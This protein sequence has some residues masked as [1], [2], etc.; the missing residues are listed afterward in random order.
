M[1]HNCGGF[2]LT[3]DCEGLWGMADNR[4]VVRRGTINDS[5]LKLA[6]EYILRVLQEN[7]LKA[8]AAFVT[9]FA[10]Q[11]DLLRD[12]IPLIEQLAVF[13]PNWFNLILSALRCK[14]LDGWRG[15]GFYRAMSSAGF[16]MAWHGA[17]HL[18]L[19][20][21]T[22]ADAIALEIELASR[23]FQALGHTPRTV[24]FPRNEVGHLRELRGHGFDT[25]RI[26]LPS[27]IVNRLLRM[28]NEWN[29]WDSGSIHKPAMRGDW[30]ISPAG[31]VLNWPS[32]ARGAVPVGTTINRWK[33]ILRS[34]ARRGGYVHMWFHPHNLITAPAMTVAFEEIMRFAGDLVKAGELVSLTI[35]EANEYYQPKVTSKSDALV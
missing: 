2:T 1:I 7:D 22:P 3:L 19:S 33:S 34:A 4:S 11:T 35:S 27:N 25:Y 5:S 21:E 12:Q 6:Y 29:V 8:T 17:T 30:H 15:A 20:D 16:E 31:Y 23:M 24:V 32:G 26:G 10:V 28:A 18:L 9:C 13:N 14:K